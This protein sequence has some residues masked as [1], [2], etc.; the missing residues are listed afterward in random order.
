MFSDVAGF[1]AM[2]EGLTPEALVGLINDYLDAMTE[3]VER[4]GGF[5]DKYIGDAIVAVF[6]APLDDPAH[7]RRGVETA[8]A[9]IETLERM[10]DRGAFV[11]RRL[12]IRIGLNSGRALV[13]NIGSKR[14]FNYTVMGDTVNLASRLEGVNKVYGT[15]ILASEATVAAAAAVDGPALAWREVDRV[16][17][18]GRSAPIAIVEPLGPAAALSAEQNGRLSAYAAALARWRDAAFADAAGRFAALAE[19]GPARH[20]AAEAASLA[21]RGAPPGWEPINSLQEK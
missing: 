21:Q 14:R 7:A 9:C 12:A 8:L 5:V 13:G 15:R 1:T 19:D 2:A 6:G 20:F 3:I 10:N 17:V 16:R 18:K 4:H 11:G